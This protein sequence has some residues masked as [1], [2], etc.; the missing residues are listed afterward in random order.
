[1]VLGFGPILL[2]PSPARSYQQTLAN[3]DTPGCT[4]LHSPEKSPMPASSITVGKELS[5]C[6]VQLICN[7]QPPISTNLPGGEDGGGIESVCPFA[8]NGVNRSS[9]EKRVSSFADE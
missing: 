9:K 6:P 5:A 8:I 2:H 7:C 4:R 3:F 1:M